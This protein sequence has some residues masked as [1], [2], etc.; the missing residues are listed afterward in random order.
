MTGNVIDAGD[1]LSIPAAAVGIQGLQSSHCSTDICLEFVLEPFEPLVCLSFHLQSSDLQ[2]ILLCPFDD[3]HLHL[4][5]G[6]H[7]F[8][9]LNIHLEI[10]EPFDFAVRQ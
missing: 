4:K 2:L 8:K 1:S 6:R 7:G 3:I 9:L 10:I 5:T